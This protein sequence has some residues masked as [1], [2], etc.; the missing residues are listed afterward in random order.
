MK[1]T[2]DPPLLLV[3][4][5]DE[6]RRRRFVRG[7]STKK[8]TEGWTV[9]PMG[10]EEHTVLD[11]VLSTTGVLFPGK[12]LCVVHNP[13]KLPLPLVKSH[14]ADSDPSVVLLLVYETDK[15]SGPLADLVPK[16]SCKV[17]PLPPFYK[18]DEYAADY[19]R[20]ARS[21]GFVIGSDLAGALVRKVGNDLGVLTFEVAKACLLAKAKGGK[22]ITPEILRD[23]VA[24]LSEVDGSSVLEALG[25]ANPKRLAVELS[26]YKI[27]KGGDPTVELCGR[28]LT[29][30]V[31]RWL[32]A[33]H[34][35]ECGVSASAA[36]G[37][38]G[39]NPWY[40]ENKVL[41][42][43]RAHGVVGCKKML[44]AIA[45]AQTAVFSGHVSP[46][47]TLEAGL[48]GALGTT[49]T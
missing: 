40:W 41:P 44:G 12:A 13:E 20:E 32:Q 38:T 33:A 8:Q 42:P 9:Y 25:S 39:S 48:L 43:A 36:A 7:V 27:S 30:M 29:P 23:T 37:R 35:F 6:H 2:S 46:W 14:A 47:V 17:F 24:P 21:K 16:A 31:L 11:T 45:K 19:V 34:M 10:G 1:A 22:D 26:R 4:G 18:L 3:A 5:A 28:V 15:P 49:G